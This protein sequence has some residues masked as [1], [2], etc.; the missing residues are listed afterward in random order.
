MFLKLDLANGVPMPPAGIIGTT[1]AFVASAASSAQIWRDFSI[2]LAQHSFVGLS[3][4]YTRNRHRETLGDPKDALFISN[5]EDSDVERL[6]RRQGP[7]CTMAAWVAGEVG[8]KSWSD[9]PRNDAAAP[10]G[11]GYTLSFPETSPREKGVLLLRAEPGL[12]QESVDALWHA[13]GEGLWALS[14]LVHLRLSRMPLGAQDRRLT[15]RQ[16][17]VLE[18]VADGK[19]ALDIQVLTGLSVSG[20]EKHLRRARD[21]LMVETTAQAVAKAALMNQLFTAQAA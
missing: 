20:V 5:H 14:S 8:A 10:V 3:Y 7:A 9:W 2:C 19:T 18:W 11:A 4:G 17:E 1:M 6:F 16:R 12:C 21:V 15:P 13:Q